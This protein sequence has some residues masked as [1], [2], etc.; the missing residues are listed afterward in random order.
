MKSR[1]EHLN[2]L[3]WRLR[4]MRRLWAAGAEPEENFLPPI[5]VEPAADGILDAPGDGG[6]VGGGKPT[7]VKG[8]ALFQSGPTAKVEVLIDGRVAGRARLGLPRPDLVADKDPPQAAIAGFELNEEIDLG[9][10]GGRPTMTVRATSAAG[11]T[12]EMVAAE[13]DVLP[14]PEP[15]PGEHP[16]PARTG[17]PAEKRSLS[18]LVV[19]HQLNLGGAQLYLMD[20]LREMAKSGEVDFTVFT[21]LDGMLREELEAMDIPVH[22]SGIAPY[23]DLSAHVGRVEEMVDWAEGREFDV[24]L[25]NTATLQLLPAVVAAEM[26]E[27]PVV[28]A[29]HES[30]QPHTLWAGSDPAVLERAEAAVGRAAKLVFEADATKRIFEAMAAAERCVTLPYGLDLAPIDSRREGFDRAAERRQRGIPEDAELVVCVGTVEPRK[31]QT[32][33]AEAFDLVAGGHPRARLAFVGGREDADSEALQAFIGVATHGER[34]ELIPITPD[35]DAWYGIA[36]LLVCASDVE[37]LPRTVLEAMAWG[38]P[39]LAT[40]VFGLPEL[41]EDGRTGWLCEARD[42]GALAAA[43]D[44]ALS[45]SAAEREAVATAARE[46]VAE[47]HDLPRYGN[48][49]LGLLQEAAGR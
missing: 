6:E 48:Q 15:D 44:R 4:A 36:D 41:I 16:P 7:V 24:A 31:A 18:V 17:R 3:R 1:E 30:F 32:M 33:L 29:I 26:I 8:W 40:D 38:T 9:P 12:F 23:D 39:V 28:W 13:L 10:P 43:L 21:A 25:V 11:E 42:L 22:V 34:M 46:L 37:S 47:R 5:K 14:E 35:V 49:V 45:T 19:T 27:I 20:L 2:G